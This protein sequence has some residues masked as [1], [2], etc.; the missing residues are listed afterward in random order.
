MKKRGRLSTAFALATAVPLFVTTVGACAKALQSIYTNTASCVTVEEGDD[1]FTLKCA[2]PGGSRI[3]AILSYWDG[4][5]FVAYDPYYKPGGKARL[6]AIA[7]DASR[8][9]GQKIEWRMRE[10]KPCAAVV[11]IHN[12]KAGILAVSDLATGDPL[13]DVGTNAQAHR[14]ADKACLS[15]AKASS[16]VILSDTG[17][18][19]LKTAAAAPVSQES[20]T[21]AARRGQKAFDDVY[22]KGGI[23]SAI[24]D[25]KSC[26]HKLRKQINPAGSAGL[27]YCGAMD[28][29]GGNVDTMMA[30]GNPQLMQKYFDRGRATD[31][32]IADGMR[33][34]GLSRQQR[35]AFERELASALGAT[36]N[37]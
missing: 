16:S 9:F 14:L 18:S 13:G 15:N 23:S 17:P 33:K 22:R 35:T 25:I 10:G 7:S 8:V 31:K 2:A 30:Q 24:D 6:H 4:R 36:L 28:I 3:H 5:A 20:V 1:R 12:T 19:S 37:D 29:L 34:L 27:A 21:E 11:R 26:Y 32:R